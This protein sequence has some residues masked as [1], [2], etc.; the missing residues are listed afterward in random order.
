MLYTLSI[1]LK[2]LSMKKLKYY[3]YTISQCLW[4]QWLKYLVKVRKLRLLPWKSKSFMIQLCFY[5]VYILIFKSFQISCQAATH[6][7]MYFTLQERAR[8]L[9]EQSG[10]P[11]LILLFRSMLQMPYRCPV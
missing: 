3:K 7:R 9:Q 2:Q 6:K 8:S 1:F 4:T 5:S 11:F 10:G